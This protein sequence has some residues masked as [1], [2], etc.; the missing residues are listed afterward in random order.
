[1]GDYSF[2]GQDITNHGYQIYRLRKIIDESEKGS[3]TKPFHGNFDRDEI[4]HGRVFTS[5]NTKYYIYLESPIEAFDS[6]IKI[7]REQLLYISVI[8]F[9]LAFIITVLMSRRISKPIEEL[10]DTAKKFGEGDYEV[11][12]KAQGYREIEELSGVLDNA[13]DE[14]KKVTDLKKELIANV[15]HD[16]R[17]PLT[18][19][20]AYAEMI[21][22]LSGNNPE[23]RE[24]HCQIIIDEADRLSALVNNLL[25]LSK[26]ESGNMELELSDFSIV[27]KLNDCMTRYTLLIEQNGYD[28][29]YEPDEDRIITADVGKLDQVIYNFIN[30]AINYTGDNKVIRIRQ[31][32]KPD[33]VRVEVVDN[34]NGISK[35]TLPLVFDR[36]YRDAKVKRAIVGT[37]LGLSICKEILKQHGFAFGVSST[38]GEGSTF[39]FEAPYAKQNKKQLSDG[40]DKK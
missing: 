29:K 38:E 16:L 40:K 19:V 12:F 26:L 7:I 14:V 1:M 37:G 15:S 27:D 5:G 36:Y 3:I 8:L 2:I 13:R 23:K 39:W 30:N 10:T 34:G 9:E 25:E 4:F 24:K 31:I 18:M 11:E 21:R 17:T 22:D 33:C 28:I 35:E 6:T 32:N 20:K